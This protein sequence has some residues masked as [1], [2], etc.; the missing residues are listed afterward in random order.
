MLP[1]RIA[2]ASGETDPPGVKPVVGA[3]DEVMICLGMEAL[4]CS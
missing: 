2:C 4:A 1:N 3:D